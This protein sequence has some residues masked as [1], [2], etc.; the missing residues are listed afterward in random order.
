MKQD[1]L[2]NILMT[3]ILNEEMTSSLKEVCETI[4]DTA[5]RQNDFIEKIPVIGTILGLS[6]GA[7]EI[8]HRLY[9]SKLSSFIFETSKSSSPDRERYRKKLE[10]EPKEAEK[11]G[12]VILDL[13]DK[14][15]SKE[16]AI[17]IGQVFRAFMAEKDMSFRQLLYLA[18]IIERAYLQDLLSLRDSE[19]HNDSNLE[20][21][22]IRKPIR[23][24]DIDLLIKD[25]INQ[26]NDRI[27]ENK[28]S[29]KNPEPKVQVSGLTDAGYHLTRI[30]RS[31]N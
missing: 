3:S 8:K 29:I 15:T 17:M 12:A 27:R 21:V 7:I 30:L 9:V 2:P 1:N 20:A 23:H 6:K 16:K 31:Y 26:L 28:E 24:E 4:L 14:V 22:G 5:I 13:I 10:A 11:A 25:L 18:E 19:I